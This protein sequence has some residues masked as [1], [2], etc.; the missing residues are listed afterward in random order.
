MEQPATTQYVLPD[1]VIALAPMR[2]VVLFSNALVPI[3]VGRARY[4]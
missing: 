2:N 1:E 3:T 4:Y